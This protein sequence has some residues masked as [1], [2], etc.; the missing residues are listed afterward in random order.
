M[1]TAPRVRVQR[2][3]GGQHLVEAGARRVGG[4]GGRFDFGAQQVADFVVKDQRQAGD[5]QQQ[6]EDGAPRLDHLWVQLQRRRAVGLSMVW[7]RGQQVAQA[8]VRRASPQCRAARA[9]SVAVKKSGSSQ[10][11]R[12]HRKTVGA[13]G[14]L[15]TGLK[16]RLWLAENLNFTLQIGLFVFDVVVKAVVLEKSP[17]PERRV[18]LFWGGRVCRQDQRVPAQGVS[19]TALGVCYQNR[20]C[21]RL[22]IKRC[23]PIWLEVARAGHAHAGGCTVLRS[24][25][26]A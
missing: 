8:H 18:R 13:G 12:K 21:W 2:L 9:A 3:R 4:H 10:T 17:L 26:A 11:T 23:R 6:H 22:W 15:R 20:S 25:C 24:A 1:R 14:S 16:G 19:S 7:G 5:A